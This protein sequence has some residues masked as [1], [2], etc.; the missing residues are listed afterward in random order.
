[1]RLDFVTAGYRMDLSYIGGAERK[2]RHSV[3]TVAQMMYF[4]ASGKA[5]KGKQK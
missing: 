1:L 2:Y 3:I 4:R 5:F